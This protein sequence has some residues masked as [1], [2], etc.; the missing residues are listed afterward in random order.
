MVERPEQ[1]DVVLSDPE[2][3]RNSAFNSVPFSDH[4]LSWIPDLVDDQDF[5]NILNADEAAS[6][7]SAASMSM[8]MKRSRVF[9]DYFGYFDTVKA[10]EVNETQNLT[11][12]EVMNT[13]IR[14]KLK[15]I[16]ASV[17]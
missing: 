2:T 12:P 7:S 11:L 8:I 16:P 9:R 14:E 17:R 15:I 5:Y 3:L 6:I 10:V 1:M 13:V 4:N